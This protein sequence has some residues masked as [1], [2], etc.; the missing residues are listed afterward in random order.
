MMTLSER[1][2][3]INPSATLTISAKA[4]AMKAKGV[5]VLNFSAGEPDFDT[6]K[7]IKEAASKALAEGFTKYTPAGGIPELKEAIVAKYEKELGITYGLSE[8]M[9][10]NGGKHALH[11]ILQRLEVQMQHALYK[12]W[13]M[14]HQHPMRFHY[15]LHNF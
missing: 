13:M 14:L 9:V 6:P 7:A 8:V 12:K 4:K 5:P 2:K 10:S 11:N 1:A 15:I 3:R